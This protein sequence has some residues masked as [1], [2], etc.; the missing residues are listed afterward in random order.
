VSDSEANV[1]ATADFAGL[2]TV[3]VQEELA[4]PEGFYQGAT[5][6]LE[7]LAAWL[8]ATKLVVND[9]VS[10]RTVDNTKKLI[11]E[12]ARHAADKLRDR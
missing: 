9:E 4:R 3:S 10:Q 2:D 1:T 12:Q 6:S 8:E 7:R 11:A 5:W